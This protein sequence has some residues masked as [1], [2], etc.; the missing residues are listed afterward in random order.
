MAP[1]NIVSNV[2]FA[3]CAAFMPVFFAAIGNRLCDKAV[4]KRLKDSR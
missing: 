1:L 4:G 2:I 3:N